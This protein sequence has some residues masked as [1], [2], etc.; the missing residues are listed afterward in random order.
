MMNTNTNTKAATKESA[1]YFIRDTKNTNVPLMG[2]LLIYCNSMDMMLAH[3][4]TDAAEAE[5]LCGMLNRGEIEYENSEYEIVML[6]TRVRVEPEKRYFVRR[7]SAGAD[8]T[9]YGE[10]MMPVTN[11]AEMLQYGMTYRDA[12]NWANCLMK[13]V[14]E[15][16]DDAWEVLEFTFFV[17]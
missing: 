5:R 13:G 7:A 11:E 9:I 3:G 6:P 8:D 1:L 12:E 4:I 17:A 15:E 16:W 10:D 2:D 14:W